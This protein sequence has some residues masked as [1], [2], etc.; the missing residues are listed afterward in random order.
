MQTIQNDRMYWW[1]SL[2]LNLFWVLLVFSSL[3]NQQLYSYF[4]SDTLYLPSLFKDVFID[5]SGIRG[6]HLNAAP[7]FFP[8]MGTYFLFNAVIGDF[9]LAM[10]L[11]SLCQYAVLLLLLNLLFKAAIPSIGLSSLTLANLLMLLFL[12]VTTCA[13]DFVF[14]FYLLSISYHLGPFLMTLAV[15]CLL[16]P[17]LRSGESRKLFWMAF[18]V[19]VATLSNRLFIVMLVFP[20]MILLPF[21]LLKAHRRR[22][23]LSLAVIAVFTLLGII[24][25]NLVKSAGIIHIIGTDWK[26]FQFYN[27]GESLRVMSGQHGRYL[28]LMD[29]RGVIVLLSL[30]SFLVTC[31]IAIRETAGLLR[32][33]TKDQESWLQA[34]YVC[35]FCAFFLIVLFMPVINGSYVGWA[36]L[37]YNVQVFYLAIFNYAFLF[38]YF[39][40]KQVPAGRH[41]RLA[42]KVVTAFALAGTL[43]YG[44]AQP[45][46]KGLSSFLNYYPD[47]VESVDAFSRETGLQY[48]VAEYWYAKK[49]TMFSRNEVRLYTV[50]PDMAIWY[51]VM[52][53][54][55]YYK[56]GK[57]RYAVPEFRFVLTNKLHPEAISQYLGEPLQSHD[58]IGYLNIQT[59]PAFCFDKQTRRPFLCKP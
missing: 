56:G 37:R 53:R 11:Y 8:D 10:M 15:L 24:A 20:S 6:W 21:S 4:N 57:G 26:V 52:N 14:T 9:K 50:H 7:N 47:Y 46:K 27:M 34:F 54:N 28:Q 33:R 48:G 38:W 41:F 35:F 1:I 12:F 18:F 51:H 3:N 29:L 45:I 5:G 2:L 58:Y 16:I 31:L 23:L 32:S 43:V 36:I 30:I 39:F 49:I 25:F 55:W 59:F 22:I 40:E 17:Y 19:F 44:A 13:G 42:A